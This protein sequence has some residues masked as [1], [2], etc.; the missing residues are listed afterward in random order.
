MTGETVPVVLTSSPV[1]TSVWLTMTTSKGTRFSFPAVP[2]DAG[3]VCDFVD[4]G[5]VVTTRI[6]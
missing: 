2:A 3:E 6:G 5:T 4:A 1:T